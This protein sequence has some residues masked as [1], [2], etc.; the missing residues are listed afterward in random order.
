MRAIAFGFQKG[1][2]SLPL[3]E[4]FSMPVIIRDRSRISQEKSA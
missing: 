4:P 3:S 1:S 2:E